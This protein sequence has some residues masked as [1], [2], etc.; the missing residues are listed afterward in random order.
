VF[1]ANPDYTT[2]GKAMARNAIQEMGYTTLAVLTSAETNAKIFAEA[3]ANEAK[4]LGATVLTFETYGKDSPDLHDQFIN[5]RKSAVGTASRLWFD[6]KLT[7]PELQ[8][9]LRAGAN[10]EL[11]NEMRKK[12]ESVEVTALFGPHGAR[13]ADSLHLKVYTPGI[14]AQ[15][16]DIPVTAIQALCISVGSAEEIGVVAS[17]LSYFNIKT[18]ILGNSEWNAPNELEANKRYLNGSIFLADS[19]ENNEDSSYIQFSRS[20]INQQ[21]KKP[22]KNTLYGYDTMKMVLD[23]IDRGAT[24]RDELAFSLAS[25]KKYSGMHSSISFDHRRVNS[26]VHILQYYNGTITNIAEVS[27]Y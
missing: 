14:Y 16:I 25:V 8:A 3:F 7:R 21:G 23:A 10:R 20:F 18:Q 6:E 2:R 27:A 9:I 4:L 13:I 1:Q 22:S 26:F 15:S 5:L 19:Y 12:H 11:L 24:T 17:Q